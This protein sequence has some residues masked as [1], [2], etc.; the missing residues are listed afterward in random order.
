MSLS[1]GHQLITVTHKEPLKDD[2]DAD[3]LSVTATLT[4]EVTK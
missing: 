2:P 3:Y 1:K 4:Y